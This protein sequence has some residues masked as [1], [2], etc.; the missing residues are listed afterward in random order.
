MEEKQGKPHNIGTIG[1]VDSLVF[2]VGSKSKNKE[3]ICDVTYKLNEVQ[4]E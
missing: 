4:K 3:I 1:P 2:T